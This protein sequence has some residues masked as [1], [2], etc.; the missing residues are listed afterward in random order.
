MM[1]KGS[2]K[3]IHYF[4]DDSVGLYNVDQDQGETTNLASSQPE[5]AATLLAELKAWQKTV[6][7]PIPTAPNPLFGKVKADGE[8][9]EKGKKKKKAKKTK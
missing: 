8:S 3:L 9:K 1:R 2:Y 6:D 4:E 5:L 7:A